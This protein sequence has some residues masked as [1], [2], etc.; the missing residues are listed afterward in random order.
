MSQ[1]PIPSTFGTFFEHLVTQGTG[2][3]V[4][5]TPLVEHGIPK[6]D[7]YWP[8]SVSQPQLIDDQWKISLLSEQ[9]ARDYFDAET[10]PLAHQVPRLRVRHLQIES[11]T[12]EHQ[13]PLVQLHFEGWPDHGALDPQVLIGLVEAI[14]ASLQRSAEPRGPVW[15]HCS[16]GLGRSGTLMGAYLVQQQNAAQRASQQALSLAGHVTAHL[17]NYRA[18]SIQTPGQLLVLAQA[19]EQ[20]L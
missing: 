4:N 8:T 14:H 1:A 17:R 12:N 9:D 10:T 7:A 6:S 18:G 3:L 13:H 16:A 2:V 5:L 15:A 11:L 20:A 19:V